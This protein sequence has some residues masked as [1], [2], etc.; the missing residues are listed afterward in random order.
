MAGEG[1]GDLVKRVGDLVMGMGG[2]DLV[3]GEV[4]TSLPP[5][6]ITPLPDHITTTNK[7]NGQWAGGTHP[8]GM[9]TC[10]SIKIIQGQYMSL[11]RILSISDYV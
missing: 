6:H 2:C 8:T 10:P 3:R 5:D 7:E 4:T 1:A 11:K 9:H